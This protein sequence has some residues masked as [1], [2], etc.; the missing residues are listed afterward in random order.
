[1]VATNT[2]LERLVIV[3]NASKDGTFDFLKNLPLGGL[4][5]NNDNLGCGVA[6]NQGILHFQSEW[7][8][9]MN[10]DVIVSPFW[11][12]KLIQ[13]AEDL[14]VKIISPALVEGPL[15]YDFSEFESY[16]SQKMANTHRLGSKHAVC[17][18]VHKSV[19]ES[20]GYFSP[21]PKLLGYE[22]TLFFNLA[23]KAGIRTAMTGSVWLHHF[24]SITQS[25]MKLEKGLKQKDG[26]GYRYNYRL[27]N[28]SW[29]ERKIAKSKRKK[30]TRV[31][32]ESELAEFGMS[33]H[34]IR[35]GGNFHWI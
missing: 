5:R 23:E 3:D 1:M 35:E 33:I 8:I 26:L 32:Q 28:Q 13:V 11:I 17:L 6:W 12:E 20:I 16:A 2:P 9:I 30:Q 7:T 31:W 34:A 27:L 14:D 18:V 19:W 29:L 22:D 10:N 21:T 4:I 24:G 15:D 25:L